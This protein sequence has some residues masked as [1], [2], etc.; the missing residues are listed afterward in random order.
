MLKEEPAKN[1]DKIIWN[2]IGS[3]TGLD[4]EEQGK[5]YNY[6]IWLKEYGQQYYTENR[7]KKMQ[8]AKKWTEA[9]RERRNENRRIN[10][11]KKNY[12]VNIYI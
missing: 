7:E 6:T 5:V 4:R 10:Y 2:V 12:I 3:G 11:R 9:N 8:Q 1:I